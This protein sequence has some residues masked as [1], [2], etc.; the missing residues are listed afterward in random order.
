MQV[1]YQRGIHLP[2]PALWLDPHRPQPLAVVSHAHAD[3]VQGHDDVV[4]SVPTAAFMRLR[5]VTKPR[6][7]T[8]RF[9][10]PH[11]IGA[12]KVTLYPA[13]HILGSAQALVEYDGIRLLYSGDFKLRPGKSTE[14]IE[15]PEADVVVMETTFGRPRYR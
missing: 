4:S 3:H 11:R 10:Q 13:G 9:G 6:F 1:L 15:V 7:K 12:A 5:G 8:L 14:P 2:G